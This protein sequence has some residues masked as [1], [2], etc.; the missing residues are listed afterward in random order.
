MESVV[1]YLKLIESHT[2]K[3]EA[4][5]IIQSA[6]SS[7]ITT[8]FDPPLVFDDE[9]KYEISLLGLE[10]YYSFP[11]VGPHNNKIKFND[12]IIT[13]ET[14]CYEL[15]NLNK[16]IKRLITEGGG[17]GNSINFE[18]NKNTFKSIL[19]ITEGTVDFTIKN[20]LRDL[21][22]FE[23]KTYKKGRHISEHVV[24]IM[25]VN[26]ILLHCDIISGSYVNGAE[27]PVIFSFFP[28]VSPGQKIVLT[29]RS[30]IYLPLTVQRVS[31]ITSW[32]T[33]QHSNELDLRGEELTIKYH[34]KPC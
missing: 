17:D 10:S 6:N 1:E 30:L 25:S 24:N 20:S 21:L 26:S 16:E 2:K 15:V 22:G 19:T 9:C 27:K 11:N 29:P 34:I 18:A 7:K 23:A 12:Q 5:H 4:F 8:F 31:R 32:L 3:K 28:A 33:D 13:L 14:G